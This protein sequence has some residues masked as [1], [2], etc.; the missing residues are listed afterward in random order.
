VEHP[1]QS[2]EAFEGAEFEEFVE[3]ERRGLTVTRPSAVEARQQV[4]ERCPRAWGA[5]V[6]RGERRLSDHRAKKALGCRRGLLD[7]D[8]LRGRPADP[9]P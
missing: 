3:Q 5:R 1:P 6:G 9:I 2:G 8:V 7:V 4:I